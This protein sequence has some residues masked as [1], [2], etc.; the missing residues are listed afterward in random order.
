MI[1]EMLWEGMVESG[2]IIPGDEI[3]PQPAMMVGDVDGAPVGQG[4]YHSPDDGVKWG[5]CKHETLFFKENRTIVACKCGLELPADGVKKLEGGELLGETVETI[6]RRL[7]ELDP[8]IARGICA[9]HRV[10][11]QINIRNAFSKA[12]QRGLEKFDSL[13]HECRRYALTTAIQ[14]LSGGR[15]AD[16]DVMAR[17]A[18]RAYK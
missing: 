5:R 4:M 15:W 7:F 11:E 10:D 17:V 16:H 12:W 1:D 8:R 3:A 14:L 6:A 2:M 18:A 13:E 9:A